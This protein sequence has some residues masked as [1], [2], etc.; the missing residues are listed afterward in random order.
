V[1]SLVFLAAIHTSAHSQQAPLKFVV[2]APS[3]KRFSGKVVVYLG[4]GTEEPRFGPNWFSPKP[5]Y[6]ADFRNGDLVK[7]VT[8]DNANAIGFPGKLHDLAPGSYTVQAV[9]DQNLGGRAIGA[10]PG[11]LYSAPI[12]MQLDPNSSGVLTLNCDQVVQEDRLQE[13]DRIKEF[14]FES[15]LLSSWYKRT[16]FINSAVVLPEAYSSDPTRKFPILYLIP[17]FGGDSEHVSDRYL[18]AT[19]RDG[20]QFIVVIL[21]PNCPTGHSVFA[22]SA[23]NGPWGMALTTEFI[24]ALEK[25]FRTF[26]DPGTRYVTGHSSGGWSSL[27]LQVAYPDVFGGVWSTSPD[28]VDFRDFQKI[29]LYEPGVNM[30][31]DPSGDPR[32]LARRGTKPILFYKAFSDME[33]PIRGEQL[34]SFE[35]VFSPKGKDGQPEK[36]WDRDTGAVDKAVAKAWQKYDIDLKLRTEWNAIG[37]K[38]AGKLHVFSGDIDTFY[39]EG[40]VRLLKT[41]MAILGSDAEIEIWPGDH[42]SV[43]TAALRGKI[44]HEMAEAFHRWRAAR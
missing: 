4:T 17:G 42:G 1:L 12:T 30:F 37:P 41:D 19:E 39:L 7:G 10:S 2:Q 16:T 5:C 34:G 24:P 23:N 13:T 18:A 38:L 36:L 29:D 9:V 31:K 20:E 27:W 21:D 43:M 26:N 3:V 40:A 22:D 15:P 25:G 32:P 33:R 8:I 44:D 14:R 28:P 6:S 35:A 11:N